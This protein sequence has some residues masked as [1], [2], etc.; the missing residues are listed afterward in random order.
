MWHQ[1]RIYL[2]DEIPGYYLTRPVHTYRPAG[3]SYQISTLNTLQVIELSDTSF[4]PDQIHRLSR[5]RILMGVHGAMIL[6]GIHCV[7]LYDDYWGQSQTVY[8]L[9]CKALSILYDAPARRPYY[10]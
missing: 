2:C 7:Q 8:W 4:F 6:M 3:D 10:T 9:S 1:L 5:T